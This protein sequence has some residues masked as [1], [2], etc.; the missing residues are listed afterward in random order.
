[1]DIDYKERKSYFVHR[2][3][4]KF[5]GV[6]CPGFHILS[7]AHRCTL[8]PKCSYCFLNLTFR[9]EKKPT[10]YTNIDKIFK[11]VKIWLDETKTPSVLNTGELSDSF[12][13]PNNKMLADLMNLFEMQS[14][15]KLLFLTKNNKIPIEIENN[16]YSKQ[17]KQTIFSFSVNSQTAAELYEKGAPG[18]FDRI[19]TAYRIKKQ[20]QH[21]R[22]RVDPILCIDD[23]KEEYKN[24]ISV[25]NDFLQ[26]ERITLGS[27]RFFKNLPNF[28]EDKDVFKY[29]MD[30][31]DGDGRLRLPLE[32]RVEI[33]QWFINNLQ[34]SDV[35]L[36]KETLSCYKLI[37]KD[38]TNKCN[39]TI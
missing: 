38:I 8:E 24:V 12:M 34:C 1:M 3:K 5:D 11:E 18:P 25:L 20:G 15:H 4:Q 37:N 7:W 27:L 10:V 32:K 22:V 33:Y 39:C 31:S 23:Y 29:G 30:H 21:L 6:I 19:A 36:C 2:F 16:I 35:T 28:T 26:P 17:Y 13:I 9:Y 14:K